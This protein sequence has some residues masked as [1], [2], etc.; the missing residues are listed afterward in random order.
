MDLKT[1]VDVLMAQNRR[2]TN[3]HQYTL[4][5]PTSYPYQWLWDS[6]FHALI[7]LRLGQLDFAK[8]ELLSLTVKQ[9]PNGMLPHMLYWQKDPSDKFPDIKWGKPDT[10]SITQPPLFAYAVQKIVDSDQDIAFLH[11][12]YP[13]LKKYY[14]YLLTTRDLNQHHLISVINPDESGE[15]NSPRFDIPLGLP[16]RHSGEENYARRLKLIAKN[17]ECNFEEKTCMS[18]F[19]WVKDVPFNVVMVVGLTCMAKLAKVANFPDDSDYYQ[20][21]AQEI[22]SA[23]RRY[24]FSEGVFSTVYGPHYQKITTKTWAIFAPMFAKLYSPDEANFIIT[25]YLTSPSHFKTPYLLPTVSV[26]DPSY[27]PVGFWRGPVWMAINWF[28]Y[29]GL[30]N[31]HREDLAQTIKD[32]SLAL[33]AKSGFREQYHPQTGGGL[34]AE[35]FTWG[36]LVLDMANH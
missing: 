17:L 25:T 16:P 9:Q 36:G 6:Y 32:S 26:S 8:N 3:S 23:M 22:A 33:L 14:D 15:D 31:Y 7:Y 20:T 24:M 35:N 28:V 19:F 27:D 12:I 30:I 2:I 5:S 11:N 1:D 4:P 34:G 10:S 21:Q 18:N 13:S 29:H